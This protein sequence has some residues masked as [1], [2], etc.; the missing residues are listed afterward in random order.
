MDNG[1]AEEVKAEAGRTGRSGALVIRRVA[2]FACI[3]LGVAALTLF[4][5]AISLGVSLVLMGCFILIET[6]VLFRWAAGGAAPEDTSQVDRAYADAAKVAIT[7][8]G[9]VLGLIAF[10]GDS[11]P[12]TTVRVGASALV[13]GVLTAAVLYL[14]VVMG[15]PSDPARKLAA[16]I[17]F[18]IAFWSLEFGLVCVVAASWP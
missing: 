16:S 3:A 7:T 14:N 12:S 17:L 8:Q 15:S 5:W 9:V 18:S 6:E 13:V 11:T 4:G 2:A 10:T 1:E